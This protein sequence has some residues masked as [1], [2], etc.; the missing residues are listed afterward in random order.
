LGNPTV[1]L[2]S[3]SSASLLL[4]DGALQKSGGTM[5]G[6]LTL[7]A[8]PTSALHA[9]T[10]QY[11]DS[12]GGGKI[13]QVLQDTYAAKSSVSV[14]IPADNTI[15]TASEGTQILAQ[16]ITLRD[17]SS[18]VLVTAQVYGGI[19]VAGDVFTAALFRGTTCIQAKSLHTNSPT[20]VYGVIPLEFL[21]AP[22]SAGAVS[23]TVR[24]GP[25][26]NAARINQFAPTSGDAFGD[27]GMCTL[28]V[29]EVLA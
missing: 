12:A 6:F 25:S 22:S 8:D 17:T 5:T 4:A 19:V 11:V 14:V 18:K 10:K 28:T 7:S 13:A 1:A 29:L 27:A 23:Y 26:A 9:A 21:D 16:A 15:P 24:V 2:N 20:R 3:A